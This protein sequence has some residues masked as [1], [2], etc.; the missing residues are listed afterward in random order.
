[1]E[2]DNKLYD[3]GAIS[4]IVAGDQEEIN[5]LNKM[6]LVETPKSL[7]Q[8]NEFADNKNWAQVASTA[9]KLKSSV[10]LWN[11]TGIENEIVQIEQKAK[12]SSTYD[13]IPP[14]LEKVNNVLK[15]VFFHLEKELK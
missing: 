15:E 1:M 3:L 5:E 14:L 6:F 12:D 9:H 4:E 7:S 11:I 13:D 8:L 10:R 2:K